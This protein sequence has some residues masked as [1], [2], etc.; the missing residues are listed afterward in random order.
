[1]KLCFSFAFDQTKICQLHQCQLKVLFKLTMQSLL[2][3]HQFPHKLFSFKS[4]TKH[5]LCFF[6]RHL[7]CFV[8]LALCFIRLRAVC[9]SACFLLYPPSYVML[10]HLCFTRNP[11]LL[12]LLSDTLWI[13]T[14]TLPFLCINY[15]FEWKWFWLLA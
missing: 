3:F 8:P 1:M 7:V 11:F 13:E 12:F 5:W 9:C 10:F 4:I 2:R 15:Y 6:I 14:S